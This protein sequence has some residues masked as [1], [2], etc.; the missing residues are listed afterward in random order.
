M[1]FKVFTINTRAAQVKI[2]FIWIQSKTLIVMLIVIMD[3]REPAW[4]MDRQKQVIDQGVGLLFSWQPESI[5]FQKQ[6]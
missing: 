1:N 5:F 3:K 4:I 6:V 2:P